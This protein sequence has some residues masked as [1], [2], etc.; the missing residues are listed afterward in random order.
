VHSG[1]IPAP[2]LMLEFTTLPKT[3]HMAFGVFSVSKI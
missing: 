2:K 3:K 1:S